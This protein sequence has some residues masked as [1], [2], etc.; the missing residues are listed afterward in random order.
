MAKSEACELWIEQEIESGLEEGK[1]P[2][3]IGKEIS[4]WVAKLFEVRIKPHTITMRVHRQ[5]NEV[6]TDVINQS[7]Q[8]EKQEVIQSNIPSLTDAGGKREGAG[9]PKIPKKEI[10]TTEFKES[11]DQFYGEIQNAKMEHWKNTTK[12]ATLKFMHNIYDLI[13][14]S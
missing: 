9:R 11:F 2:Y 13:T 3:K 1:T 14:I 5:K 7:N 12:E 10:F 8:V 6:I 4:G